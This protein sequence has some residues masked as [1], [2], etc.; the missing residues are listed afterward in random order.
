MNFIKNL[1]RWFYS[2]NHKVVGVLSKTFAQL[3][4]L[5]GHIKEK[6]PFVSEVLLVESLFLAGLDLCLFVSL[7][8][9]LFYLLVIY[10]ILYKFQYIK[11]FK[12]IIVSIWK[13]LLGSFFISPNDLL[14]FNYEEELFNFLLK[15]KH[16]FVYFKTYKSLFFL[17]FLWNSFFQNVLFLIVT[18]NL[19][20]Y[21]FLFIYLFLY[22]SIFYFL[23]F[24]N[25]GFIFSLISLFII[26][27]RL[28]FLICENP[29]SYNSLIT[30]LS[31]FNAEVKTKKLAFTVKNI[32]IIRIFVV[33]ALYC[34]EEVIN[35]LKIGTLECQI[36][37]QDKL[38]IPSTNLY[39][40]LDLSSNPNNYLILFAGFVTTP[41]NT[42]SSSIKLVKLVDT[43]HGYLKSQKAHI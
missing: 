42:N 27:F 8:I 12:L 7:P 3:A 21:N 41:S 15:K 1:N 36:F 33:R 2:I 38:E 23:L 17:L 14:K 28:L 26:L 29:C 39:I 9:K 11:K 25:L 37:L 5:L 13:K 24:L 20:L 35:N 32:K 31:V 40:E 30:N 34:Y 10:I 18:F 16:R 22:Y 19:F 4:G 43:N 6:M